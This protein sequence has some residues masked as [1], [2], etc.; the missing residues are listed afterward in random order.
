M[1]FPP[2]TNPA[3]F[4]GNVGPEIFYNLAEFKNLA[5]GSDFR[6]RILVALE[7]AYTNLKGHLA[8]MPMQMFSP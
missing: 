7:A 4:P 1:C 3:G 5:T 2:T 6:Y 8:L